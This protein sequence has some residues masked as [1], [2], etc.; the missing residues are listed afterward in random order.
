MGTQ[1]ILTATIDDLGAQGELISVA[2]GYAR[3]FLIPKGLAIP[4]TPGNKRRIEFLRKKHTEELGKQL[5]DAKTL[6]AKLAQFTGSIKAKVGTDNK[7]F[8]SVGP[9][10][11]ADALKG[12]G[13]NVDRR[14]IV[15]EK[16]IHEAG[17][18][19]IEAKLHAEVTAK[20]KVVVEASSTDAG[21][22]KDAKTKKAAKKAS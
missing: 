21:P 18:F 3:N 15:L 14:K 13:I 8:G 19:D 4:A 1:I 22:V 12:A 2:N 5:D 17:I 10:E 20:F 16:P 11:I 6:A 9:A 7:L